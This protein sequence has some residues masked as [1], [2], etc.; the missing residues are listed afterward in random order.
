LEH[1]QKQ[2]IAHGEVDLRYGATGE[3]PSLYLRDPEGNNI[4]LKGG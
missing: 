4:E 2:G 1:L 3:G